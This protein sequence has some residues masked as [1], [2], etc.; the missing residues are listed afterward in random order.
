MP[1]IHFLSKFF[2]LWYNVLNGFF[3][4]IRKFNQGL[5]FYYIWSNKELLICLMHLLKY[6]FNPFQANVPILYPLQT[7]ENQRFSG[8]FRG[9]KMGALAWNGLRLKTSS[10]ENPLLWGLTI[11]L[12]SKIS[13]C[14]TTPITIWTSSK[15]FPYYHYTISIL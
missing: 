6:L 5:L 11:V 10:N 13:T 4:F 7:P 1:Y 2:F 15:S 14:N 8:V 9:C 3:I 12:T